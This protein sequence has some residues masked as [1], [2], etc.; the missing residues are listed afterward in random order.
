MVTN[1]LGFQVYIIATSII[2]PTNLTRGVSYQSLWKKVVLPLYH[3]KQ[4][5]TAKIQFCVPNSIEVFVRHTHQVRN[6]KHAI[7]SK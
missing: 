5:T 7:K 3:V 2:F 4:P 1:L 6:T